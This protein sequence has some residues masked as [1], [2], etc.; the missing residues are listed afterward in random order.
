VAAVFADTAYYV[1]L[2]YDRDALHESAVAFDG[3]DQSV[4]TLTTDSVLVEVLAYFSSRG[5]SAR[6]AAVRFVDALAA[7]ARVTLIHQARDLFFA[8][9]DLYRQ[10][11]DK[12][13]SL[14]DCMSMVVCRDESIEQVLTHDRHFQQEG[15]EILL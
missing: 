13:Y 11:L 3:R 10:R 8:G 5:S 2:L 6:A 15:F 1:A 4:R 12:G 14:T 9:V 7:D